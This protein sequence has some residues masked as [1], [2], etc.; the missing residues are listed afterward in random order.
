LGKARL[1]RAFSFAGSFAVQARA[2]IEQS[3]AK[4]LPTNNWIERFA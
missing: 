4:Q 1:S 2:G 3:A